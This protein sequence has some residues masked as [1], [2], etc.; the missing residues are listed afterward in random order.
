MDMLAYSLFHQILPV[1][2]T[3]NHGANA[4]PAL[5]QPLAG[6]AECCDLK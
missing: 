3:S 1:Q 2:T 6:E 5:R 4:L